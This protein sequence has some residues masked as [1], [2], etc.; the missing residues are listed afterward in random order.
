MIV[1]SVKPEEG[2][3]HHWKHFQAADFP[4]NPLPARGARPV[5]WSGTF[6]KLFSFE[7][8]KI[9]WKAWK[10]LTLLCMASPRWPSIPLSRIQ[11][12]FPR[13]GRSRQPNLPEKKSLQCLKHQVLINCMILIAAPPLPSGRKHCL[14]QR[15]QSGRWKLHLLVSTTH[16]PQQT[17]KIAQ[18]YPKWLKLN[19]ND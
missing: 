10:I 9:G 7:N 16:S 4:P 15:N 1:Y 3:L 14:H 5:L 19:W 18:N 8:Y 13:L 6:T 2:Y 17:P 12:K 11:D